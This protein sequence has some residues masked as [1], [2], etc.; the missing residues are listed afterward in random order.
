MMHKR[1]SFILLVLCML[2]KLYGQ[3]KPSFYLNEGLIND[4]PLLIGYKNWLVCY[5]NSG[6]GGIIIGKRISIWDINAGLLVKN[7]EIGN[8]QLIGIRLSAAAHFLIIE[9]DSRYLIYPVERLQKPVILMKNLYSGLLQIDDKTETAFAYNNKKIWK[10]DLSEKQQPAK[11][12]QQM[13]H[14][15]DW[16]I[17]AIVYD[18]LLYIKNASDVT[19][20]DL[21][22][23]KVSNQINLDAVLPEKR[24]WFNAI[25][26]MKGGKTLLLQ[27]VENGHS[28]LVYYDIAKHL[29]LDELSLNFPV[30]HNLIS[31]DNSDYLIF[32]RE[33]DYS[34]SAVKGFQFAAIKID[35]QQLQYQYFN[36]PVAD[37][38]N[39]S[40]GYLQYN[41][42]LLTYLE[43]YKHLH[44]YHTAKNEV[45]VL[46]DSNQINKAAI[47]SN[48]LL[49]IQHKIQS[50]SLVI[51]LVDFKANSI[52][53]LPT[54]AIQQLY[55]LSGLT[56]NASFNLIQSKSDGWHLVR[57]ESCCTYQE[58]FRLNITAQKIT[59]RISTKIGGELLFSLTADYNSE[60]DVF[61]IPPIFNFNEKLHSLLYN[62]N[63]GSTTAV[64]FEQSNYNYLP[65]QSNAYFTYT[66]SQRYPGIVD[67]FTISTYNQKLIATGT[68]E[69]WRNQFG[70]YLPSA[71]Q[72][73]IS[74]NEQL[75]LLT[76][77]SNK[78]LLFKTGNKGL[79]LLHEITY[80]YF[81]VP[82]IGFCNNDQY[83]YV[84]TN[85]FVY[86]YSTESGKRVSTIPITQNSGSQ[87]AV[88]NT[89]PFL[90]TTTNYPSKK[91]RIVMLT[92]TSKQFFIDWENKEWLF[93]EMQVGVSE[94]A[95]QAYLYEATGSLSI[96]DLT[97]KKVIAKKQI[98][99]IKPAFFLSASKFLYFTAEGKPAIWDYILKKESVFKTGIAVGSLA[100]YFMR[101]SDSILISTA[102]NNIY[103]W[104]IKKQTLQYNLIVSDTSGNCFIQDNDGYYTAA[105]Q[106]AYAVLSLINNQPTVAA[107]IGLLY[108][109]PDRFVQ[110]SSLKKRFYELYQ[111]RI[112]NS[113]QKAID[114]STVAIPRIQISAPDNTASI[115]QNANKTIQIKGIA[116][117]APFSKLLI[118]INEVLVLQ[119][120]VD[121]KAS[122]DTSITLLLDTGIN[123]IAV[124]GINTDG[125]ESNRANLTAYYKQ[126]TADSV[127]GKVWFIGIGVSSYKDSSMNLRYAAKDICDLASIIRAKYPNAVVDT[128]MNAA[129]TKNI[130]SVIRQNLSKTSIYDRVII[131]MSGHG[132]LDKNNNFYYATHDMNFNNPAATGI[133]YDSIEAVINTI[134]ARKRV[135]LIDACNSGE[136]DKSTPNQPFN[137]STIPAMAK[138]VKGYEIKGGKL[139]R[140]SNTSGLQNSFLLM[141]QLFADFSEMNGTVVIAA[142]AGTE[143]ALEDDRYQNGVFTYVIKKALQEKA[144]DVDGDGTITINEFKQYVSENVFSLTGGK[145]T[146][147]VRKEIILNNW[148][149]W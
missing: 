118:H 145:Q 128:F 5:P 124:Y 28:I 42:G 83:I 126:P 131:S 71:S 101:P 58:L 69:E 1:F 80:D 115:Q 35:N 63:T 74:K 98:K 81:G 51:T 38:K 44:Y 32:K 111:K 24:Y 134:A 103:L 85:E 59:P 96:L 56:G 139:L 17:K 137:N 14:L 2:F 67:S 119:V 26:P 33:T 121:K 43:D 99:Q 88:S 110:D 11:A 102:T 41:S 148:Q 142:S 136:L 37:Q 40:Y 109:R 47:L 72:P 21:L 52:Q 6:N 127:S 23:D 123:Q 92:D 16:S 48:D 4:Q 78:I 57:Q 125:I 27:T 70:L 94:Y 95:A 84:T 147:A 138:Q 66:F 104:N 82:T 61:T 22:T 50:D 31:S 106:Q 68:A 45:N 29:V 19:I 141:K 76:K 132:M 91:V 108:N 130:L 64:S 25:H 113:K 8:E 7:I 144:A 105:K 73:I 13:V 135:L 39:F 55:T 9:L 53:S 36:F 3:Q 116:S 12:L 20:I 89:A 120:P 90:I 87:L 149:I 100:D 60:A 112:G 93:N 62:L 34:D 46:S 65:N 54:K 97:S 77:S 146:P 79:T 49:L 18:N 86:I 15:E 143:F 122:I 114:L 107:Q 133:M 10:L 30:N 129:V 75:L 117:T 140:S